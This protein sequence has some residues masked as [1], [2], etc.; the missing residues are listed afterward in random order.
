MKQ[1]LLFFFSL[2]SLRAI[3]QLQKVEL[4]PVVKIGEAKIVGE[5]IAW[6]NYIASNSDTTYYLKFKNAKYSTLTDIQTI[7]FENTPGILD[8]LYNTLRAAIE[9]DN[10][11]EI[12]LILGKEVLLLKEERAM[13]MKFITIIKTGAYFSLR[14][15][16][17]D[18]LFNR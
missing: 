9:M 14:K 13:G 15:K 1:T 6:L 17:L 7:T 12:S 3:S 10:G 2:I 5:P 11:K 8:S 16:Q 4:S 18:S